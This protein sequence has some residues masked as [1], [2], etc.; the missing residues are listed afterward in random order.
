MG[1]ATHR[2]ADF[3]AMRFGVDGSIM[4]WG[5]ED[6]EN[7][8]AF[9]PTDAMVELQVRAWGGGEPAPSTGPRLILIEKSEDPLPGSYT[10]KDAGG[11]ASWRST[12][13]DGDPMASRLEIVALTGDRH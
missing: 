10:T 13:R 1:Y 5:D 12:L 11:W 9:V 2:P 7:D 8:L 6:G 4:R 3:T